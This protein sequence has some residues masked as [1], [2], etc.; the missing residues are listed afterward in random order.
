[1]TG[2]ENFKKS[3]LACRNKELLEKKLEALELSKLELIIMKR[4]YIDGLFIK[5]I[6]EFSGVSERWVKKVHARAINKTLDG[7]RWLICWSWVFPLKSRQ[8][9]YLRHSFQLS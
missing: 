5:Q 9:H 3:L 1:M 4:R 8:G 2:L 7:F 6:P